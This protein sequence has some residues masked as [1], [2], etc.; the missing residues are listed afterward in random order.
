[1]AVKTPH[2]KQTK[3]WATRTPLKSCM[4]SCAAYA[5]L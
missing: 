3:D 5:P 1:M 2:R 4:H